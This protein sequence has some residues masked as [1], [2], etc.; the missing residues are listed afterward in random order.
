MNTYNTAA[1]PH[2]Q[3]HLSRPGPLVL[4]AGHQLNKAPSKTLIPTN[5]N[6]N[7]NPYA[8]NY[9]PSNGT[10]RMKA[11]DINNNNNNNHTT[12]NANYQYEQQVAHGSASNHNPARNPVYSRQQPTSSTVAIAAK[13]AAA[14]P[15]NINIS[16]SNITTSHNI[17]SH[18]N[19]GLSKQLTTTSSNSNGF[20]PSTTSY[21]SSSSS[22]G[23]G[24][25]I[26]KVAFASAANRPF[27]ANTN[28]T[29]TSATDI[30][31]KY[32]SSATSATSGSYRTKSGLPWTPSLPSANRYP[33]AGHTTTTNS[34]NFTRLD[35]GQQAI[36][37][38]TSAISNSIDSCQVNNNKD[39]QLPSRANL[40]QQQQQQQNLNR[41]HHINQPDP[42][43]PIY[44]S[45][46]CKGTLS[47]TYL[48]SNYYRPNYLSSPRTAVVNAGNQE[49]PKQQFQL[50][51]TRSIFDKPTTTGSYFGSHKA[52]Q[53]MMS[54]S[55]AYQTVSH[56]PAYD[57]QIR[58]TVTAR[59]IRPD[60]ST[61]FNDNL[62]STTSTSGKIPTMTRPTD[63]KPNTMQYEMNNHPRSSYLLS[64]KTIDMDKRNAAEAARV[65]LTNNVHS[66][67]SM[68]PVV[69]ST[70]AKNRQPQA[71]PQTTSS[72]SYLGKP[73]RTTSLKLRNSYTSILDQ[74]AS[75]T[76]AKLRLV[77]GGNNSTNNNNETPTPASK[78]EQRL[79]ETMGTQKSIT[80]KAA[81]VASLSSNV[82][83]S[84]TAINIT[85]DHVD[86]ARDHALSPKSIEK[87][88]L[89]IQP[90]ASPSGSTQS[91]SSSSGFSSGPVGNHNLVTMS[92]ASSTSSTNQNPSLAFTK[93]NNNVKEI[94]SS[95]DDDK[96][97]STTMKGLVRSMTMLKSSSSHHDNHNEDSGKDDSHHIHTSNTLAIH[98]SLGSCAGSI[99][100][101]STGTGEDSNSNKQ[102]SS[103]RG[104]AHDLD[105][106]DD[107]DTSSSSAT[108][109][110]SS[111]DDNEHDSSDDNNNDTQAVP[112]QRSR[113]TVLNN[114]NLCS[115]QF[116]IVMGDGTNR[117]TTATTRKISNIIDNQ[118]MK[119]TSEHQRHHT[120]S[121]HG[122][123]FSKWL[124][125]QS[126]DFNQPPL[127]TTTKVSKGLT[128]DK[129][130]D[131]IQTRQT[132]MEKQHGNLLASSDDDELDND[133]GGQGKGADEVSDESAR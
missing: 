98:R 116:E 22:G 90:M 49:Q 46:S 38:A 9:T 21:K 3:Q 94:K 99:S 73:F 4:G 47:S 117:T 107:E 79:P 43:K 35:A 54:P 80:A 70:A 6:N 59:Y 45:P 125:T 126:G 10:T 69:S 28:T 83:R 66:R 13:A 130:I 56:R 18:T 86:D 16:N 55:A 106:E 65:I 57:G 85:Y 30:A 118:K 58:R 42:G 37:S 119:A 133:D 113:T 62:P 60:F 67:D 44:R 24:G 1:S 123:L 7:N 40:F 91:S 132:N 31:N 129:G 32:P 88:Q 72:N 68:L 128:E 36:G 96:K 25:A 114:N 121:S 104:S 63:N 75:S 51:S 84:K 110:S 95:F 109:T 5:S 124:P 33:L 2:Y 87:P 20:Y 93:N 100:L 52:Q 11:S 50:Q 120:V 127:S 61:S 64:E 108:T 105:D 29:N 92:P 131:I 53:T 19:P 23:G 39:S 14:L 115:S 15:P 78:K 76:L 122:S 26:S 103:S 34:N 111:D 77:S 48:S 27:K 97:S 17:N 81:P 112:I 89:E 74:L 101:S 12:S 82:V 102:H 8:I 41:N 71:E